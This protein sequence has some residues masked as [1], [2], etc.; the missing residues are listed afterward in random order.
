VSIVI[1]VPFEM[2]QVF[3]MLSL[4]LLYK[5]LRGKQ[6]IQG[7]DYLS[8]GYVFNTRKISKEKVEAAEKNLKKLKRISSYNVE[9]SFYSIAFDHPER[10]LSKSNKESCK[11]NRR[12]GK[13]SPFKKHKPVACTCLKQF[14]S[15]LL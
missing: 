7:K 12:V 2:L 10:Q 15:S 14:H 9:V 13:T 3:E 6:H 4:V 8:F 5:G 11:Q 1:L